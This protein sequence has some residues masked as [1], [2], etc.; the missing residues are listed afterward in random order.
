M[1]SGSS[2]TDLVKV[3]LNNVTTKHKAIYCVTIVFYEMA[4]IAFRRVWHIIEA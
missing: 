2:E 1:K 3:K 4:E